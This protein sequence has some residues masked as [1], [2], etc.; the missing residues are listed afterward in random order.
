MNC[1]L[2]SNGYVFRTEQEVAYNNNGSMVIKSAMTHI[3]GGVCGT[4]STGYTWVNQHIVKS[5]ELN[6]K[7]IVMSW[8][9]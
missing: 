8:I 6:S 9:E 7:D 4:L 5:V 1:F 2:L 3:E